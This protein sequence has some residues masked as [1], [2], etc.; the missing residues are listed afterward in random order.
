[1]L[2]KVTESAK[3]LKEDL[4]EALERELGLSPFQRA[5]MNVMLPEVESFLVYL[6]KNK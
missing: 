1:M 6:E 4:K 3:A 5:A 2:T